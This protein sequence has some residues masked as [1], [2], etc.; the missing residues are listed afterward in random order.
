MTTQVESSQWVPAAKPPITERGAIGWLYHN[1]FSSIGNSILT[2]I[3]A[4][5]L[6]L[7]ISGVIRWILNA[8]WQPVWVNRKLFAVGPYPTE[9]LSQPL[10]VLVV[11]CLL[12]GLSAG[13]WGSIM[14]DIG[15][16]LAAILGVLAIIPIGINT[17]LWLAGGLVLLILGY[18]VGLV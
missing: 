4:I 11:L 1:L 8:F 15:I 17:Q 12:F 10:F 6:Y 5:L 14:R 9:E 3:T 2:I 16:G 7:A 18:I 13:R